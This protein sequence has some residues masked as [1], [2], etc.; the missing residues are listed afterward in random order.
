MFQHYQNKLTLQQEQKSMVNLTEDRKLF[1]Q[2]T[3]LMKKNILMVLFF[4]T[5]LGALKVLRLL[6]E[7]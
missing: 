3:A 4:G 6:E 7:M 5:N 2:H 1:R